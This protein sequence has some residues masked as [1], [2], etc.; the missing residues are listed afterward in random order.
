MNYFIEIS[1]EAEEDTNDAFVWYEMQQTGLGDYFL[2]RLNKAI[3]FL[4]YS[5]DSFRI[6]YHGIHRMM[7]KTFPY[8]IDA[9][10]NVVE[11]LRLV[12]QKRHPDYWKKRLPE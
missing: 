7:L 4:E 2:N 6:I 12:H 3:A 9:E 11:V 1:S 5:P 10:T 8:H